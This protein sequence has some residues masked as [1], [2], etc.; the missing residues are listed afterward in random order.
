MVERKGLVWI[1]RECLRATAVA[2]I[3]RGG[4][5]VSARVGEA[6]AVRESLS[7]RQA[8]VATGSH[9]R[10]DIADGDI[11]CERR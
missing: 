5:V 9:N 3:H 6:A 2:V 10:R 7:R 11:V 1:E 8:H 4:P